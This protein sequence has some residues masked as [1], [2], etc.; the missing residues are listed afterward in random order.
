M[1]HGKSGI[2]LDNLPGTSEFE[3]EF[4]IKTLSLITDSDH[5][6]SL[7][8]YAHER[9]KKLFSWDSIAEDWIN[10]LKL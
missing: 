7:Q 10:F 4:V 1:E 9:A 2:I 5:L 6:L 3:E 8:K